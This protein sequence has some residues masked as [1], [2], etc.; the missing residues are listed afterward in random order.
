MEEPDRR[1]LELFHAVQ[2]GASCGEGPSGGKSIYVSRSRIDIKLG[3]MAGEEQFENYMRLEGY[4]MMYPEQLPFPEQL[5]L[6][7]SAERLVFS[8]G[9]A[10]HSAIL[11]ARTKAKIS[12]ILRRPGMDVWI[13]KFFSSI[14][15]KADIINCV[16]RHDTFGLSPH[17]GV[18]IVDFLAVSERLAQAGFVQNPYFKWPSFSHEAI[19]DHYNRYVA[20]V[21]RETGFV[22]PGKV[23]ERKS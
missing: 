7:R 6:Y 5:R 21:E 19:R 12:V 3:R 4:E 9:S 15:L 1:I 2:S 23:P 17:M 22:H 20:R 8:E 14:S 18:S 16:Q 13:Q 11:F 10:I